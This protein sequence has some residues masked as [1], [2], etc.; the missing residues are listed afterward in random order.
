MIPWTDESLLSRES[1]NMWQMPLRAVWTWTAAIFKLVVLAKA[2]KN[3]SSMVE[4][5][6]V[7]RFSLQAKPFKCTLHSMFNRNFCVFVA[8]WCFRSYV[9]SYKFL[10]W[11]FVQYIIPWAA[12]SFARFLS[13]IGLIQVL[14]RVEMHCKS[15]PVFRRFIRAS[16][17]HTSNIVM[18]YHHHRYWQTLLMK[19]MTMSPVE[20][21]N[22]LHTFHA[23]YWPTETA[24]SRSIAWQ[25]Q[26]IFI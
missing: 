3:I 11:F 13:I 15:F 17:A 21:C 2:F 7:T 16:P 9:F 4:V 18:E 24:T 8:A 22:V 19:A 5:V 12:L 14:E 23:N 25:T 1:Q 6:I 20:S 26:D 10:F